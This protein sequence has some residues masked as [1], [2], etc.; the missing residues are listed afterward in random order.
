MNFFN[1]LMSGSGVSKLGSSDTSLTNLRN[2]VD[3]I[4]TIISVGLGLVTA[5][6]V[7]LAIFI[8]YKFFTADSEDKRKNAKAQLIYAIIGVVV[9]IALMVFAPMILN[10][11]TGALKTE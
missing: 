9:L 11:V 4:K 1:S 3:N 6:V 7:I 5:G 2:I 8:A 10:A